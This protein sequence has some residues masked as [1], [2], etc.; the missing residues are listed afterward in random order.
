[1]LMSAITDHGDLQSYHYHDDLI[2]KPFDI[3]DFK[4]KVGQYA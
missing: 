4:N 3:V 2:S 1:L